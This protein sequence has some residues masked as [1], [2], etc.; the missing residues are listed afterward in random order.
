MYDLK[1]HGKSIAE[2]LAKFFLA[3]SFINKVFENYIFLMKL[4][5]MRYPF[6]SQKRPFLGYF[7]YY[8]FDVRSSDNF[9]PCL[10]SKL[11]R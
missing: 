7:S 9:C 3:H 5:C 2:F 10:I 6:N 1:G 8:N 11:K 4:K